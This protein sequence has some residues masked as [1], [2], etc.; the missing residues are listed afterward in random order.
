MLNLKLQ[1]FDHL[2]QRANSLEKTLMLGKIEGKRRRGQQRM[3][4]LDS[5]TDSLGMN[6]RKLWEIVEEEEAS[7]LAVSGV[8]ENWIQLSTEQQ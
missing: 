8:A 3:K 1:Y 5:I 4:W 7:V 2:M 6:L